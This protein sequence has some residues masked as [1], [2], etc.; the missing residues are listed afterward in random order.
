[1]DECCNAK[2]SELQNLVGDKRE[3][4]WIV[5]VINAVMFVVEASYG[6]IARSTSLSAD[7]LDMLGDVLVYGISI[8]AIGRSIRWNSSVSFIKGGLMTVLG[9]GVVAQ[10]VYRYLTPGMPIAE[11][12]GWVAGLAL[13]ANLTCAMLLLRHRNDDL[14]MR[15]TWLCSRNDV[16]SN[17]GVLVAAWAV[18]VTQSKAPDLIVGIAIAVLVLRSAFVVLTE[19][20]AQLRGLTHPPRI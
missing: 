11:T 6:L 3:T 7:S 18:A 12:M 16:V 5:L 1:M 13:V 14:N 9:V 20:F 19:S 10:A 4:L 8:F 2:A 17:V 15:S